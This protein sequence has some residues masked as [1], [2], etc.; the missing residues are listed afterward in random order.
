MKP[1]K[2][3]KA[4]ATKPT[5]VYSADLEYRKKLTCTLDY[6]RAS[7]AQK[8]SESIDLRN[9]AELLCQ[10]GY[11]TTARAAEIVKLRS[12]ASELDKCGSMLYTAA[13]VVSSELRGLGGPIWD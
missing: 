13:N 2:K 12:E 4:K 1:K 9:R 6:L 10:W 11:D 5:T 3:A 7:A 8:V